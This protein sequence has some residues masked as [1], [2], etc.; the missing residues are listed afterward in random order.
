MQTVALNPAQI[1]VLNVMS[2]LDRDED[3]SELSLGDS[4]DS[5]LKL[6]L[7]HLKPIFKVQ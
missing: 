3:L 5:L 7:A 6:H 2:C 4:V 1:E